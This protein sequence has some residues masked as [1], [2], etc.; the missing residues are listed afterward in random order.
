MRR[1]Y[2]NRGGKFIVAVKSKGKIRVY[3]DARTTGMIG[4]R[5]DISIEKVDPYEKDAIIENCSFE[6]V[7]GIDY[8]S[9]DEKEWEKIINEAEE[10]RFEVATTELKTNIGF[11]LEDIILYG[12]IKEYH[13]DYVD[14]IKKN[15]ERYKVR[16]INKIRKIVESNEWISEKAKRKILEILL[17][18]ML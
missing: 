13:K 1:W 16:Y 2:G 5:K 6:K 18:D 14:E 17:G 9:I 8:A 7:A 10:S 4:A 15:I 12:R 3:T 11:L